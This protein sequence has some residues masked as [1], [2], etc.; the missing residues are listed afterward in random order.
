MPS[1]APGDSADATAA[2]APTELGG[3]TWDTLDDAPFARIEAAAAAHD[4]EIWLAGG[5]NAD[6]SATEETWRYDP[7]GGTWSPGPALPDAL[8]HAAMVSTGEALLLIGGYRGASFSVPVDQVLRLMP[9]AAGWV[10]DEPLPE[11]RAAGAAAWD[12][13]RIVYAGGVRG[14]G[15]VSDGVLGW[16]GERWFT[17]GAMASPREHLSATSDGVGRV[18]LLGGRSLSLDTNVGT[19]EIV[20]GS[21][22]ARVA[23][24]P[25][26][27]G[28][29][30][31]FHLPEVGACLAGGE[32]P[33]G[34]FDVVE[35][36]DDGLDV[37]RL[38]DMAGPRHGHAAAVLD[39][40]VYVL[41]GGPEP[42]L[43]VSGTV[44]RLASDGRQP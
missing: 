29:A 18:W 43:T 14:G 28:G 24:L 36:I 26:P 12:G 15:A 13:E 40:V 7:T 21:L 22:V 44:Q 23:Q 34:A 3:M 2:A 35:C 20:E 6:G 1:R 8:H 32:E 42:L 30:A 27:R 4:G 11:P 31:A 41:L 5:L 39:G 17:I 38:S 19:V 16:D 9:D 33:S 37:V 25:T 10:A